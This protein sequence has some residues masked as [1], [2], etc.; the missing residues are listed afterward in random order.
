[1][2]EDDVFLH[3]KKFHERV[4]HIVNENEYFRDLIK[5]LQIDSKIRDQL[6]YECTKLEKKLGDLKTEATNSIIQNMPSQVAH[7]ITLQMPSYLSQNAEMQ[8]ILKTH[9]GELE[10]ELEVKA[11]NILQS[12]VD[13]PQYHAINKIYF[14]SLDKKADQELFLMRNNQS[15]L[16]SELKE[17]IDKKL[18]CVTEM[19]NDAKNLHMEIDSLSFYLKLSYGIIGVLGAFSAYSNFSKSF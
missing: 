16:Y 11:R 17:K 7:Q 19:Q 10:K 12:I 18:A 14:E 5:N 6:N 4:T 2:N 15:E 1:M 3:S 9:S 13:D 8:K